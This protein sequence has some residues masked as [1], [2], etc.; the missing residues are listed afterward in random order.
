M[1]TNK[2]IIYYYGSQRIDNFLP[3]VAQASCT[4]VPLGKRTLRSENASRLVNG[5]TVFTVKMIKVG[6]KS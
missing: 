1:P 5:L 4:A 2:N 6:F 3:A